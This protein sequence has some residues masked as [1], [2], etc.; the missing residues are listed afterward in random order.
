MSGDTIH[1][2]E[3]AIRI[4][5][6]YD[7]P[8]RRGVRSQMTIERT[9]EHGPGDCRYR[10]GLCRAAWPAVLTTRRRRL[11][12]S[13]TV[14]DAESEHAATFSGIQLIFTIVRPGL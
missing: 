2:F 12:D 7:F 14:I 5:V 10:G 9:G 3:L 11:P 8:G 1:R 4:V 13:L 6:P